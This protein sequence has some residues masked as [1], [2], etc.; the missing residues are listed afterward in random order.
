MS[1]KDIQ[2]KKK[3]SKDSSSTKKKIGKASAK[4]DKNILLIEKLTIENK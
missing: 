2:S 1:S 3:S 4:V